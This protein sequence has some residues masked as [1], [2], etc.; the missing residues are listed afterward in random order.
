MEV[1]WDN[2]LNRDLIDSQ[3]DLPDNAIYQF[4]VNRNYWDTQVKKNLTSAYVKNIPRSR[5]IMRTHIGSQW[6]H[7]RHILVAEDF[8]EIA[9]MKK[10]GMKGCT[11]FAEAS[12]FHV[13]NEINYLAFAQFTYHADMTWDKFVQNTLALILGNKEFAEAYLRLLVIPNKHND[14]TIAIAASRSIA[15]QQTNEDIYRRWIWLQNR[16]FKQPWM[17]EAM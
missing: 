14:L 6:H 4:C 5:N 2:I 7:E 17:L 10:N 15:V 8:A 1:Y 9:T 16:L 11:I 13:V 12:S 3:K